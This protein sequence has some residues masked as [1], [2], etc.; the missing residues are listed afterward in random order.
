V[1]LRAMKQGEEF[2]AR[3]EL[4]G[5]PRA[6]DRSLRTAWRCWPGVAPYRGDGRK[7][8]ASTVVACQLPRYLRRP[9]AAPSS[10]T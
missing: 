2:F 6:V 1:I 8:A 9:A 10:S 5:D 4:R 7:G 3:P